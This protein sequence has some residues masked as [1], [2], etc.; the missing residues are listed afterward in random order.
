M[1]LVC[2]PSYL[3]SQQWA[4]A[5][6]QLDPSAVLGPGGKESQT[7]LCENGRVCV[8]WGQ[9]GDG[10]RQRDKDSK[11]SSWKYWLINKTEMDLNFGPGTYWLCD[12]LLVA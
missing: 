1:A 2:R 4:S 5:G 3:I 6:W 10:E 7:W 11:G 9:G 8:G 12:F